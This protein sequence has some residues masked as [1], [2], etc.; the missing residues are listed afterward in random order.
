MQAAGWEPAARGLTRG[1][2]EDEMRRSSSLLTCLVAIAALAACSSGGSPAPT[3]A[4]PANAGGSPAAGSSAACNPPRQDGVT[5]TFASFGGSYQDAQKKAWLEPY[6]QATGVQFINEE[7][8]SNA[9]IK[10]QVEAGQVTWDVA[11]V[12]NDFGLDANKDLLEPLD[13][14]L[15]PRDELNPHLGL[16]TYRMPIMTYGV[17]LAYN[18]SKT[19]AEAP[20][21]WADFFDTAKFPGKR[22]AYDSPTGGMFEVALLADGVAPADLYPLDL[23]RATRKLD[24][25]KNDI[26]FWTSGA[27]S[28]ELI[29]SGEVAMSFMWNGRA[30]GAKHDD[31][32]P[33]EIQWKQQIVTADYIVMPKGAPNKEAGMRFI[34]YMACAANNGR[35]SDFISYGPANVNS[36]ANPDMVNDLSV[37]H[38]DASSA[39][40]DDAYLV[41]HFD[42]LDAAWQSW[43]SG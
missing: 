21:G 32:K 43:K 33:V 15:I 4:T 26:V 24:S 20:Q 2:G 41:D 17:V 13:Y 3:A 5:L 16:G 40:F 25:I 36:K 14:S 37:S 42:E 11:D 30:W 12:G 29:G 18:T 22:G 31:G 34:A 10:A 19:G 6:T 39:Y 28:R 27:Q 1:S 35:L 8:V 9:K 7:S 38:V 23:P